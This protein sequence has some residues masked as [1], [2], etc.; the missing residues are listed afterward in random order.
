MKTSV[1]TRQ[2]VA[3]SNLGAF[4]DHRRQRLLALID[5]AQRGEGTAELEWPEQHDIV[6]AAHRT[7]GAGTRDIG[8]TA[9]GIENRLVTLDN[10]LR[11]HSAILRAGATAITVPGPLVDLELPTIDRSLKASWGDAGETDPGIDMVGSTPHRLAAFI[12]V[13]K[14]LLLQAPALA[15]SYIEAQLLSAVGAAIDDA[16]INGTG[17]GQPFGLLTDSAIA[18]HEILDSAIAFPDVLAMEKALADAHGEDASGMGWIADT[19]TRQALRGTRSAALPIPAWTDGPTGGPLGYPGI[20]SPWAP[21]A[22]LVYAHFPDL[23]VIQSN[24]IVVSATQTKSDALAGRLTLDINS[25]FD[26]VATNPA[27]SFIRA[28]EA[29]A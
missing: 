5:L 19:A 21:A 6:T 13:S 2:T 7:A 22:T 27:A 26:V 4:D 23:L 16:A 29:E 3:A 25:F 28:V 18:E 15:A 1:L 8:P 20:A 12:T 17:T 24:R 11:R 9:I 10:Q 14:Q